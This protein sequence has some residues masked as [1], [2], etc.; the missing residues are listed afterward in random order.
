MH[1]CKNSLLIG[2]LGE[3]YTFANKKKKKKKKKREERKEED[4]IKI[5]N[6][7]FL[8][9]SLV[10]SIGDRLTSIVFPIRRYSF[11]WCDMLPPPPPLSSISSISSSP[12][13]MLK[14]HYDTR[15]W[16]YASS[17]SS[18]SPSSSPLTL[19]KRKKM[20]KKMLHLFV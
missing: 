3:M 1:L 16:I 12:K 8:R 17:T 10:M 18:F 14:P 19:G 6:A 7:W 4:Q 5:I 2:L 15:L 11:L 13:T 9:K 20:D